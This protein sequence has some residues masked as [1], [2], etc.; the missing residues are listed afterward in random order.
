VEIIY[1]L[2]VGFPINNIISR[3]SGAT[4]IS[5]YSIDSVDT[6]MIC[7]SDLIYFELDPDAFKS[8]VSSL[9][10]MDTTTMSHSPT[11]LPV[12]NIQYPSI[13][14]IL[15][16]YFR[17]LYYVF[18]PQTLWKMDQ[19]DACLSQNSEFLQCSQWVVGFVIHCICND[20]IHVGLKQKNKIFSHFLDKTALHPHKLF[21]EL[22]KSKCFKQLP[23]EAK[24][25]VSGGKIPI[26]KNTF[27][28]PGYIV[29]YLNHH[30]LGV[31]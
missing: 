8:L 5:K 26:K 16:D 25:T 15:S 31:F 21:K 11:G 14:T 1:D 28:V 4:Q 20:S 24:I 19:A 29:D 6:K 13:N 2:P 22:L 9:T 7:G 30:S 27:T 3:K 12:N 17:S 10:N 18:V 23:E